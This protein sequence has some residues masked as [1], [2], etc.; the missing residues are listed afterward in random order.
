MHETLM[1]DIV[2]TLRYVGFG[3]Y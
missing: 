2:K 1:Q 3:L